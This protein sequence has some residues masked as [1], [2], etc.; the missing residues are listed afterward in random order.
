M[1]TAVR[2]AAE[3]R[4]EEQVAIAAAERAR[5]EYERLRDEDLSVLAD[6]SERLKFQIRSEFVTADLQTSL[7]RLFNLLFLY[8]EMS[9]RLIVSTNEYQNIEDDVR[10]SEER[11]RSIVRYLI[12]RGLDLS[13]FSLRTVNG[14]QL[15]FGTHRVRVLVEEQEP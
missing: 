5:L 15:Q 14:E 4:T 2:I 6:L 7:D 10:V 12:D 3:A 13:R 11:G 1:A 9:V 8:P